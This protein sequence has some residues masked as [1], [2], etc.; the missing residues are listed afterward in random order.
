[1]WYNYSM[2]SQ[3]YLNQISVKPASNAPESGLDKILKSKYTWIIGGGVLLFILIAIIGAIIGSGSVSLENEL[4]KLQLRID[5]T[6]E[7]ISEYQPKVRSSALRSSSA[8]LSTVLANT[9]SKLTSYLAE[10]YDYKKNNKDNKKITEQI[11]TE[12]DG[13]LNELFEAKIT[14]VLDRTYAQKM[15]FEVSKIL[16][17]ESNINKKNRDDELQGI[18]NESYGSLENL[19]DNL[20]GFSEGS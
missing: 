13:L 12:Q 1:M 8:S 6:S 15:A 11:K 17:E 10:K 19:Y 2:E 20:N 18:I 16:T 9:S 4:I 7:V 14:G 3:D 5:S